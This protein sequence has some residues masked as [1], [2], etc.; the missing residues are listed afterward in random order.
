MPDRLAHQA[1]TR[2]GTYTV[3]VVGPDADAQYRW[4][5]ATDDALVEYGACYDTIDDAFA[6]GI[7]DAIWR[8]EVP[9]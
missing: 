9:R 6:D 4:H 5:V 3:T 2:I 8:T 1:H 7:A